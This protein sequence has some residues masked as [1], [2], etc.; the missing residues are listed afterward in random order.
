[1]IR[2]LLTLGVIAQLGGQGLPS[3]L[4]QGSVVEVC[5]RVTSFVSG[6]PAACDASLEVTSG[7]DPATVVVIPAVVRRG[8]D[9]G[10]EL[11]GAEICASGIVELAANATRVRVSSLDDIRVT[12]A[13]PSPAFGA[14]IAEACTTAGVVLPRVLFDVKPSYTENA[15]RERV[16]GVVEMDAIVDSGGSV[17][18][19]RVRRSL[20]PELDEQAVRALREWRFAPGTVE[21]M[22]APVVVSVEMAFTLK[23][24]R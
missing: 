11:H 8:T 23:S 24:R 19:V 12:T 20:H 13:A 16:E 5:G 22:P 18:D 17:S 6:R 14:G 3:R 2:S 4:V 7:D 9:G 10:R 21:G 15:M 1:M